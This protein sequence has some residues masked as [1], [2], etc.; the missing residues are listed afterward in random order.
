MGFEPGAP[1]DS[2]KFSL[3]AGESQ[4][5]SNQEMTGLRIRRVEEPDRSRSIRPDHTQRIFMPDYMRGLIPII[6]MCISNM[7]SSS[8]DDNG[9]VV[10]CE[11]WI[12]LIRK[13]HSEFR[14][15]SGLQ[16]SHATPVAL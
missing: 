14:I 15:R 7:R 11:A 3:I 12:N 4:G 16:L 8:P 2:S 9:M 6:S 1:Q 10:L 13:L 5:E